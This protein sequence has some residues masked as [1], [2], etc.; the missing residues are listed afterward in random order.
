MLT[1]KQIRQIYSQEYICTS[2]GKIFKSGRP[3]PNLCIE[4][5]V[6]VMRELREE[7]L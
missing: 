2:C 7:P 5:F 4:C 1:E 6:K 3:M